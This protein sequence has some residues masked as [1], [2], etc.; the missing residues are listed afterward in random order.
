[1]TDDDKRRIE[2]AAAKRRRRAGDLHGM[3]KRA[4]IPGTATSLGVPINPPAPTTPRKR[5]VR[6][7]AMPRTG[8]RRQRRPRDE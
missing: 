6:F 4:T 7:L 8:L 3:R 2:A 5:M 1:M